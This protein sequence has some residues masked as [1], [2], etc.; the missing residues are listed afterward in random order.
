M[1]GAAVNRAR[2]V[3]DEILAGEPAGRDLT[4]DEVAQVLECYGIR[5][6]PAGAVPDGAVA[7]RVASTE[8]PLFGPLVSFALA[9][10]TADLLG[11]VAYRI[12]PLRTGDVHDLVRGVRA[13]PLLLGHG[14]R[15]PVDL[16]ALETVVGRVSLLAEDLPQ[17]SSLVLEPVLAHPGGCSVA[18]AVA[19]VRPTPARTSSERRALRDATG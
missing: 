2:R 10:V 1:S 3:V 18:G 19:T 15:E 4:M 7:C 16:A 9:G 6:D 5:P 14:G 13:A 11:D 12:P 17:L 8:D